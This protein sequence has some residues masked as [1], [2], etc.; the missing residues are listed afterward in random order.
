MSDYNSVRRTNR[1][2]PSTNPQFVVPSAPQLPS[3]AQDT[4][5]HLNGQQT[6]PSIIPPPLF[7]SMAILN[8]RLR[9][10]TPNRL[11]AHMLSTNVGE[12]TVNGLTGLTNS[13]N[14]TASELSSASITNTDRATQVEGNRSRNRPS[15]LPQDGRRVEQGNITPLPRRTRGAPITDQ[16]KNTQP[17]VPLVSNNTTAMESFVTLQ[18]EQGS[19]AMHGTRKIDRP[20]SDHQTPTGT[21]RLVS[22]AQVYEAV[23]SVEKEMRNIRNNQVS[24][25]NAIGSLL[26]RSTSVM[27][28]ISAKMDVII[29]RL[30]EGAPQLITDGVRRKRSISPTNATEQKATI[31]HRLVKLNCLLAFR[32]FATSPIIFGAAADPANPICRKAAAAALQ[33]REENIGTR[34]A[35]IAGFLESYYPVLRS[36]PKKSRQGDGDPPVARTVQVAVVTKISEGQIRAHEQVS[37]GVVKLFLSH[38]PVDSPLC[39][40]ATADKTIKSEFAKRLLANNSYMLDPAYLPSWLHAG[41]ATM[42]QAHA[43]AQANR[44]WLLSHNSEFAGKLPPLWDKRNIRNAEGHVVMSLH[45]LSWLVVKVTYT[46]ISTALY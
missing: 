25:E 42:S 44:K 15:S 9:N 14:R 28:G 40:E 4:T 27:E 39:D 11:P 29:Q 8:E 33:I 24:N 12:D 7:S 35:E 43:A 23:Q 17:P 26:R 34:D 41:C 5:P 1:R 31:A 13:F 19:S 3:M 10:A 18:R 2:D 6:L 20:R 46:H 37:S 30:A 16:R 36:V 21:R 22:T 32:P 45:T 38:G